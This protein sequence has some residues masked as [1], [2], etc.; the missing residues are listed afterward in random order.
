MNKKIILFI[1][2]AII[3]LASA[4]IYFGLPSKLFKRVEILKNGGVV[5]EE[6]LVIPDTK[7]ISLIE[8]RIVTAG[9]FETT[10]MPKNDGEKIIV[11]GAVLTIKGSYEVSIVEAKK[12]ANDAKLVFIKSLGAVNLEGK[13]SEWQA[14]FG[15]KEKKKG[16]EIIIQA[17]KIVSQKEIE[18][19]LGGFDLP[20][21]W[22]DSGFAVAALQALPQFSDATISSITFYYS[23]D[24]QKWGYAFATSKGT[25]SMYAR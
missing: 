25:T 8:S 7:K 10:L 17:D 14:I 12:W 23:N 13:S 22:Q 6:N 19:E 2:V 4:G 15:S 24:A 11:S 21:I 1:L 18:S 20:Q 9:N 5:V 3:I 16:Y